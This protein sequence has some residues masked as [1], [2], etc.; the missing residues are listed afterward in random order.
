VRGARASQG[1]IFPEGFLETGATIPATVHRARRTAHRAPRMIDLHCHLLPNIDDG[2]RSVER[3]V[4]V[5]KDFAAAGVT[6]VIL[7]PHLSASEINRGGERA[8]ERR[9][10][11]FESLKAGAPDVPRLWLGFEILLDQPL[12]VLAVSDRRFSLAGSRYYLVEFP[13][14]VIPQFATG[15]LSQISRSGSVPI[16][17]HPERYEACSPEAVTAWRAAGARIQL[18][19]TT[20]TRLH[21]RGRRARELLDYGLADLVAAD[22]HGDHRSVKT[23]ADYLTERGGENVAEFLTTINPRAAVTDGDMVP[24]ERISIQMTLKERIA[25]LWGA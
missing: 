12:P 23:A 1:Q 22:N 5:L 2:S 6:D 11:A 13:L 18:D 21:N 24:V 7:T 3:S 17:A 8:I 16:V 25:R 4:T 10:H 20:I 14:T 15:V 9:L 19:A